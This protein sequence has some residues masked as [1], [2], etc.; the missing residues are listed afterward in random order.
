[1]K[2]STFGSIVT[3]TI[4]KLLPMKK[5]LFLI[6][7]LVLLSC[8]PTIPTNDASISFNSLEYNFGEL[9]YKSKAGC[10]FEFTNSGKT[11]LLIYNVKT[12]CGCTVPK[13]SKKPI[14]SGKKGV[15]NIEY[16]TLH[17]GAFNKTITVFYNGK[18]S[19]VELCIKGRV[20]YPKEIE[21]AIE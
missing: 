4:S 11:P 19:P 10:K 21:E 5:V 3:N 16:D 14:R 6:I 12:S 1:M 18:E 2:Q 13:W 17:P 8:S 15:I 9:L 7:F 20:K